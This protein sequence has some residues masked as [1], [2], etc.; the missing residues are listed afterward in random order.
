M[1]EA[2]WN[3]CHQQC[4]L[5]DDPDLEEFQLEIEES[6]L[7]ASV[8]CTPTPGKWGCAMRDWAIKSN[9]CVPFQSTADEM[10]VCRSFLSLRL[11]V[12]QLAGSFGLVVHLLGGSF[13]ELASASVPLQLAQLPLT[14][15][16]HGGLHGG[17]QPA[18]RHVHRDPGLCG[19]SHP[20]RVCWAWRPLGG[21][22]WLSGDRLGV[23]VC[24]WGERAAA[25]SGSRAV[26]REYDVCPCLRKVALPWQRAHM[27]AFLSSSLH[28]PGFS[29]T[30]RSGG[31]WVLTFLPALAT[32]TP[33]LS[34]AILAGLLLGP[35][36]D[37]HSV[38]AD[39]NRFIYPPLLG[40][41][42]GR[43]WWPVGLHHDQTCR[44]VNIHQWPPL[45]TGSFPVSVLPTR[46]PLPGG[47]GA[48]IS[49]AASPATTCLPESSPLPTFHTRPLPV[50]P[51]ALSQR[52]PKAAQ[53]PH[54]GLSGVRGDGEEL[55][56]WLIYA[57]RVQRSLQRCTPSSF[58]PRS[59]AVF[60]VLLCLVSST[61]PLSDTHCQRQREGERPRKPHWQP[62][63][64]DLGS[65]CDSEHFFSTSSYHDL[66]SSLSVRT[67]T[68]GLNSHNETSP[69]SISDRV[70]RDS[71]M[72]EHHLLG[73]SKMCLHT[74]NSQRKQQGR[75][76]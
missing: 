19:C 8:Q 74:K 48:Q 67:R 1:L 21:G 64:K 6:K 70:H 22:V 35:H 36:H 71:R 54:P 55:L 4:F 31:V 45:C 20:G 23:G 50:F 58:P 32:A 25:D 24:V 15:P 18:D 16:L 47:G 65:R 44:V 9:V 28:H 11:A 13:G 60:P 75:F 27:C 61:H 2:K 41:T 17:L 26:R 5:P 12:G 42:S 29:A 46:S 76:W 3:F 66:N 63:H 56:F 30:G 39:S 62:L 51:L 59:R 68:Q 53:G 72:W 33:L 49:S 34:T 7:Q 40:F 57:G 14:A 38:F 10:C 52:A 69:T 73:A 43:V 37:E